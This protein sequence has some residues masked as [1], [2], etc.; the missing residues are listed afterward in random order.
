MFFGKEDGTVDLALIDTSFLINKLLME[1]IELLL[2]QREEDITEGQCFLTDKNGK[3]YISKHRGTL[4][5]HNKLKIYGRLNCPSAA[6]YIAKGQYVRHRV[7]FDNE[8]TAI[9]AG[10]RPCA[11]CMPESYKVWKANKREC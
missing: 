10:Y 9:A 8:E 11:V 1:Q 4:G 5:G 6:R 2:W 3:Q 7:F